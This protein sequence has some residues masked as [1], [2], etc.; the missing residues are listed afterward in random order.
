MIICV[1][2]VENASKIGADPKKGVIVG[3][4]S[5]GGGLAAV[6]ALR[7]RDDPFFEGRPV[8]GQILDYPALVYPPAIP[9]KYV[10]GS[11]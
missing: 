4:A 3:G 5:A 9:E 8:T 6:C 11:F 2:A 7:A 10:Y 1:Q